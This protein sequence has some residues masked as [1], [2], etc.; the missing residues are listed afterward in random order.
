MQHA[1]G[2]TRRHQATSFINVNS[3][4]Y[5]SG[6]T[7]RACGE[8]DAADV[9]PRGSRAWTDP[10]SWIMTSGLD[11][12]DLQRHSTSSDPARVSWGAG[13]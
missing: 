8:R 1:P 10:R 4:P 12:H 13:G 6:N 5:A 11:G 7:A 9:P 2:L 3:V